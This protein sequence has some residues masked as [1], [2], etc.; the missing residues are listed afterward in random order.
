MNHLEQNILELYLVQMARRKKEVNK[1][2]FSGS[3]EFKRKKK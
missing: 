2:C 1:E 3:E